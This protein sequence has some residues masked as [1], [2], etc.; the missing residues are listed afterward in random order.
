M[1]LVKEPPPYDF[2]DQKGGKTDTDASPSVWSEVLRPQVS[3]CFIA[4]F[5]FN[6]FITASEAIV[7]PVTQEVFGFSPLQN[8]FVY[9]GISVIFLVLT[10][11]N[12]AVLKRF[13]SDR[14]F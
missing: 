10:I 8:S 13:L 2:V 6:F 7:V 9:C 12:I 4:I 14:Y 3:M 5:C 1:V 11:F